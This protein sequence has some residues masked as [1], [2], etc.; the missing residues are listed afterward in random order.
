V[1]LRADLDRCGKS[2]L[3]PGFDPRTFQTVGSRYTDYATRPPSAVSNMYISDLRPSQER[4]MLTRL[5][6]ESEHVGLKWD[7]VFQIGLHVTCFDFYLN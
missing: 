4:E 7:I 2:R 6:L 3:P 5:T 1:G